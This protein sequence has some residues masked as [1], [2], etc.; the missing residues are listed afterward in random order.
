MYVRLATPELG[1]KEDLSN[2]FGAN[3]EEASKLL[4]SINSRGLSPALS[5][6]VGS[7]CY[8]PEAYRVALALVKKVMDVSAIS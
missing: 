8:R 5:F 6:H 1:A 4:R 2:K 3:A 7:Q